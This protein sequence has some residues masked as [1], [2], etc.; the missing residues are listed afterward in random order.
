[1]FADLLAILLKL[2]LDVFGQI[3]VAEIFV[4]LTTV[5]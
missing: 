3:T 1:M 4:A 2:F 5:L